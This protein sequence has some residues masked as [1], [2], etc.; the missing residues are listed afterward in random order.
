MSTIR[1]IIRKEFLQ[2]FRD[3][4]MLRAMFAVPL[5][6]LFVLGYAITFDV[7][8]VGLVIR[9]ADRTN[10]SRLLVEKVQQSRRFRTLA[11]EDSQFRLKDH[12]ESG[13]AR[14][15]LSI[16]EKF[17]EDLK[18]GRQP[19]V[20]VLVNGMD[21]NTSLVAMGYIQRILADYWTALP[22]TDRTAHPVPN[23]RPVQITPRI[24]AWFNPNLESKFYMLPGI[25]AILLAIST[26]MLSG[27][28]IVRERE[29]GTLEQLSVTPIRPYQLI[30]GK[31]IPFAILSFIM[32]LFALTVILF[33]YR[34]PLVGSLP[35]L[36]LFSFI[37]L[38]TTLGVGLLVSTLAHTQQEALFMIWA[39][40]VFGI[41]MS[42]L[43]APIENMPRAAQYL[44]YLN[45]LRYFMA[46]IRDIFLKGS[47]IEYLWPNGLPLVGWGL[48]MTVISVLRFK[49]QVD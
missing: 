34:I 24:R 9:D 25:V 45:P 26:S 35:L 42:G 8:N 48:C 12:F 41:L 2:I 20:Q 27:M 32:I 17:A 7:Q 14:I 30:L 22:L 10:L 49:K 6:Q 38:F 11:Y 23:N 39:F 4:M 21:S 36:L 5:I 13:Q 47:G 29:I 15:I 16:P 1:H 43:F 44:T 28:G 31:T 40:N 18:M 37:F 3:K 19:Q 46:I 33:W